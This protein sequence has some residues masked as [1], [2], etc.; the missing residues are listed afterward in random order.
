MP[1]IDIIGDVCELKNRNESIVP[2]IILNYVSYL[3]LEG[4]VCSYLVVSVFQLSY[5]CTYM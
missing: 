1:I 3:D 2:K 4:R 5:V